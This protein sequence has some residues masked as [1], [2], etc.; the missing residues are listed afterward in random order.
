[1]WKFLYKWAIFQGICRLHYNNA[2]RNKTGWVRCD[3]LWMCDGPSFITSLLHLIISAVWISKSVFTPAF[4]LFQCNLVYKI[5]FITTVPL[6]NNPTQYGYHGAYWQYT[7][8][9]SSLQAG[10][11]T[12]LIPRF[13]V[14]IA[15]RNFVAWLVTPCSFVRCYK[16]SKDTFPPSSGYKCPWRWK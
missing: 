11:Y 6:K 5:L 9:G 2:V 14:Y 4:V 12:M 16:G 3:P 7:N 13:E 10:E 8:P 15:M 1:M